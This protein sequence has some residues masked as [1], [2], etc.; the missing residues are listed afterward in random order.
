MIPC[1]TNLI[2]IFLLMS[3]SVFSQEKVEGMAIMRFTNKKDI[4]HPINEDARFKL[5]QSAIFD[6]IEKGSTKRISVV[7]Y[8]K[9]TESGTSDNHFESFISTTLQKSGVSWKRISDYTFQLIGKKEWKCS[10]TGLVEALDVPEDDVKGLDDLNR[11]TKIM[12]TKRGLNTVHINSNQYIS[13]GQVLGIGKEIKTKVLNDYDTYHKTKAL[14]Y[15]TSVGNDFAIGRIIKGFYRVKVGDEII[16]RSDFKR[17]RVGIKFDYSPVTWLNPH[18]NNI[19][20]GLFTQSYVNRFGGSINCDL[21][22]YGL[23]EVTSKSG[24]LVIPNASVTYH[25]A[26]LPDLLYLVP[27]INIGY[28]LK[29]KDTDVQTVTLNPKISG[30]LRI[31]IVELS[32]GLQYRFF[33]DDNRSLSGL[34]PFASINFSLNKN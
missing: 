10:V 4:Y 7:N 2:F 1:R 15:I 33:L 19:S 21:L 8:N 14:I 12:V 25:L 22:Q 24:Y 27:E 31:N 13:F 18:T 6:A 9:V 16:I 29:V 11:E 3:V 30:A 28:V 26:L 32:A 34:Y 20:F 5:M 23:R 17:S